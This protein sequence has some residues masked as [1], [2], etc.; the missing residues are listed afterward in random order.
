MDEGE[1]GGRVEGVE[2]WQEGSNEALLNKGRSGGMRS[3]RVSLPTGSFIFVWERGKQDKCGERRLTGRKEGEERKL[4]RGGFFC[5]FLLLCLYG[6][7]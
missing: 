7:I 3:G 2:G 1:G 4:A 5:V 6:V